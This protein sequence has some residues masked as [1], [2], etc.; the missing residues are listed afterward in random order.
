MRNELMP[1]EVAAI[2]EGRAAV[3]V[4]PAVA[5][6]EE[7]G[8][9]WLVCANGH[10]WRGI[11]PREGCS[12]CAR[13]HK[14][15]AMG[16]PECIVDNCHTVVM[17]SES[18]WERGVRKCE[19]H[20]KEDQAK[21]FKSGPVCLDEYLSV[22]AQYNP[23]LRWN[24]WLASPHFDPWTIE[25]ILSRL[26]EEE[27]QYEWEWV[28]DDTFPGGDYTDYVMLKVVDLNAK[29]EWEEWDEATG[30][31]E[32]TYF[33]CD[34]DGLF[35]VNFGWVWSEDSD[36]CGVLVNELPCVR[37]PDHDGDHDIL[38]SSY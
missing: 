13:Y 32:P 29:R 3:P 34:E 31:F 36:V 12:T 1:V 8:S 17:C 2:A 14:F 9:L 30:D 37:Y 18:A 7:H 23:G 10:R 20:W 5:S 38:R 24:G 11:N 22:M 26:N 16:R 27:L 33:D 28:M 4:Y 21:I 19:P 25:F 15:R 35:E 6:I